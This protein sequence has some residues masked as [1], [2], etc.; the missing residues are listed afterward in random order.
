[1]GG[2]FGVVAKHGGMTAGA[3]SAEECR[4]RCERL[5][6]ALRRKGLDGALVR[7]PTA[8]LY[9]SGFAAS[10]GI[11][12]VDVRSGPTLLTD[13]RYLIAARRALTWMPCDDCG[14]GNEAKR[15]LR[16]LTRSWRRAGYEGSLA[17]AAYTAQQQ[18]LSQIAEWTDVDSLI[19]GQR[20]IK[21][22]AEQAALRRVIRAN[23]R[24][25]ERV[26]RGARPG[27]SE[28][29]IRNAV[30][31]EADTLGDGEAFDA[32]VC[33]G[34]NGAEC[35]H[36]PGDDPWL[37]GQPLLLDAGL[38]LGG[39]CSDLTRTVCCGRPSARFRE[40]HALV[41]R[42]NRTA[43]RRLRPGMTGAEVDALARDVID[44]AGHGAAFGHSLGHGLGLEV[45]EAPAFAASCKT[46]IRPGMVLTVEPGV[47]LP[48]ELGVRIE[49]VVLITPT[50]C[51]VLSKQISEQS[52]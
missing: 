2:F 10:N 40:I 31:R 11:L 39:Y 7:S 15:I 45:H 16:R 14:R 42:A 46:V 51:E 30:R 21:S 28:R 6:A 47:Y 52:Y 24:L 50:G 26:L 36:V 3:F 44:R 35:H 18:T 27:Q 29:D 23:D 49:D 37:P 9:Y 13:F 5:M 4:G 22:S 19:T 34:A 33:V 32:V 8:R 17:V 12:S 1:M 48:G 43:I 20:A 38:K 25:F 41:S